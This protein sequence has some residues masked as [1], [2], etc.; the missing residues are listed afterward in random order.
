[1]VGDTVTAAARPFAQPS[2]A[3]GL[4]QSLVERSLWSLWTG[5]Q[6]AAQAALSRAASPEEGAVSLLNALNSFVTRRVFRAEG[7]ASALR[8][9]KV[10]YKG[11]D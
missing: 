10:R 6:R 4:I 7:G 11:S 3:R 2:R 8:G 5:F 9:T 1:M